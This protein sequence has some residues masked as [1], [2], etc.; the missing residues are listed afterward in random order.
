MRRRCSFRNRVWRGEKEKEKIHSAKS[1]F[2]LLS[3]QIALYVDYLALL[4]FHKETGRQLPLEVKKNA[5]KQKSGSCWQAGELDGREQ[6]EP[7]VGRG[8]PGR[9][10]SGDSAWDCADTSH[11]RV[12]GFTEGSHRDE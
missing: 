1:S 5:N 10:G 9:K 2:R 4:F 12:E 11:T 6:S 7:A 8:W 3:P